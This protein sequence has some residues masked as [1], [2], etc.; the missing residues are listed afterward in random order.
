ML[1]PMRKP[2]GTDR[3]CPQV[4]DEIFVLGFYPTP[5]NGTQGTTQPHRAPGMEQADLCQ[6]M[7]LSMGNMPM[8]AQAGMTFS[9]RWESC[10]N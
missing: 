1:A 8:V 2:P 10:S 7:V 5:T 3:D 4:S 6:A 9:A